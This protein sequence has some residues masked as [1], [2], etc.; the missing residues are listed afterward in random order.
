MFSVQRGRWGCPTWFPSPRPIG[1]GLAVVLS[2]AAGGSAVAACAGFQP[3]CGQATQARPVE[4]P[5]FDAQ[6]QQRFQAEQ[7]LQQRRIQAQQAQQQRL[8]AEQAL[9]QRLAEQQRA[10]AQQIQQQRLQ[11]EQAQQQPLQAEQ[12]QRQRW[13]DERQRWQAQDQAERWRRDADGRSWGR[14]EEWRGRRWRVGERLPVAVLA[15]AVPFAAWQTYRLA[16]PPSG[17]ELVHYNGDALL[18]APS[19]GEVADAAYGALA[20]ASR[21]IWEGPWY[22]GQP[23]GQGTMRYPDGT[24]VSGFFRGG[25]FLGPV[26]IDY[27]DGVRYAGEQQGGRPYG[28]GTLVYPDGS[29]QSGVWDGSQLVGY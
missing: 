4:R 25:A 24:V 5:S 21:P 26:A 2:L 14:G 17:Y 7:A 20:E 27:P 13:L 12:A 19:S 15:V 10:Q 9:Q 28:R 1:A 3:G 8:V 29:Q 22:D 18:V 23:D 11:A 16:P 6:Q